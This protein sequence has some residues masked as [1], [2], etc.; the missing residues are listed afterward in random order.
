MKELDLQKTRQ[1]N[2]RRKNLKSWLIDD[3]DQAPSAFPVI[4]QLVSCLYQHELLSYTTH[5]GKKEIDKTLSL[6]PLHRP[7]AEAKADLTDDL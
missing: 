3:D 4:T 2:Y 6:Y 5:P 1:V 7:A